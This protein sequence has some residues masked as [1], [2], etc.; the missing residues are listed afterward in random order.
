MTARDILG[1]VFYGNAVGTWLVALGV[2]VGGWGALT[3]LRRLLLLRLERFAAH[4]ATP[5]D[6]LAAGA[7][8]RTRGAFLLALALVAATR[9]VLVLPPNVQSAVDLI[10][11]LAFLA[12]AIS[13]GNG[14][15]TFW[16]EHVTGRRASTDKA[17]LA[18]LNVLGIVAR[19][20]LWVLVVLLALDAFGV[21]VRTL[22][23]GLGIAGIAVAL[24][25]QNILGDLLASLSIALDKPFVIGDFI[26]VDNLR[27]TVEDIGLKTTRI[28]SLTGEQIVVSNAELLKA[29]ISNYQ[30]LAERRILFSVGITYDTPAHLVARAPQIVREIVTAQEPVRFDRS[31]FQGFLESSL[32][33]ETVYYVLVPEYNTYM[34]IQQRI[35]LAI[36]DRFRAEGISFAF[37]TRTVV[38]QNAPEA[39]G[40]ATRAAVAS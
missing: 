19:V 33:I 27:G 25:V 30:R 5:V 11:K 18:T 39:P 3:L 8:R 20:V 31:H 23:T 9:F 1:T 35:N 4:T 40:D 28:R 12:Q 10:G 14:A 38:H 2:L 24:A 7:L 6:D 36:L 29:R 13:W 21:N 17:S 37:P 32:Q 34:D 26:I 16:L 22:I 15:I